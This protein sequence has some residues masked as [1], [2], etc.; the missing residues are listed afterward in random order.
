MTDWFSATM[1]LQR[2]FLSAQQAQID[3]AQKLL[4]TGKQM[5]AM[6]QAGADAVKANMRAWKA[7]VDL[8]GMT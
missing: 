2:D 4:D 8:W 6:Q 3:A 5:A 1:K 7:W